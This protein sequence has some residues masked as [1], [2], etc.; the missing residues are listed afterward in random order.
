MHTYI[1]TYMHVY[2]HDQVADISDFVSYT[3]LVHPPRSH[4]VVWIYHNLFLHWPVSTLALLRI[5]LPRT[6]KSLWVVML[7][8]LLGKYLGVE[9]HGQT[10]AVCVTLYDIVKLFS[11]TVAP[12]YIPIS[13]TWEFRLLH[14]LGNT[15]H[16]QF[17]SVATLM[18]TQ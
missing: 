2:V 12:V 4:P 10:L 11:K 9:C 16:P 7:F 6:C 17:L 1:R 3:F 8:F 15:W 5:M 14:V 18:C 13:N